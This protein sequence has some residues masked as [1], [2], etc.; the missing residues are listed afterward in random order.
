MGTS[1]PFWYLEPV[2]T[3]RKVFPRA[4][5]N[6]IGRHSSC[7]SYLPGYM[8]LSRHHAKLI[9][10]NGRIVVLEQMNGILE[11]CNKLSLSIFHSNWI[12]ADRRYTTALKHFIHNAQQPI[13][14][15]GG[16]VLPICLAT[17][18][19]VRS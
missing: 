15:L 17:Y 10:R 16:G 12:G 18:S 1:G 2:S 6:T 3:G 19:Q 14:F 7:S 8:F 9:V 11:D 4:G 5:E 13:Q